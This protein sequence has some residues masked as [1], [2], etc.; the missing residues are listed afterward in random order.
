LPHADR[1]HAVE[2]IQYH[3]KRTN[4]RNASPSGDCAEGITAIAFCGGRNFMMIPQN[5][6]I[7]E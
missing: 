3:D 7:R 6:P 5:A 1:R 2:A 4:A